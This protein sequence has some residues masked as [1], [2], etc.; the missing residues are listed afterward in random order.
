MVN[1]QCLRKPV[2]TVPKSGTE[3]FPKNDDP[4]RS[5]CFAPLQKSR[6]NHRSF[7]WT[8]ALTGIVFVSGKELALKSR[9]PTLTRVVSCI[10][11]R[12]YHSTR[13]KSRLEVEQIL[14]WVLCITGPALVSLRSSATHIVIFDF[15]RGERI[16]GYY[17]LPS[18]LPRTCSMRKQP[19]FRDVPTGFQRNDVWE[20]SAEI[21]YWW[22]NTI[23]IW[24]MFL[25]GRKF[26]STNQKH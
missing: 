23:E 6:R 2:D 5:V 16:G 21:P 8:E 13:T 7:L 12:F 10:S 22:R 20:T 9:F 17:A 24:V 19:L 18:S 11:S 4:E 26:A 14:F 1:N 15:Y 25:I 3:P